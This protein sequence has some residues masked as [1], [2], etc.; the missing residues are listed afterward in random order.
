MPEHIHFT[1]G[2]TLKYTQ[3]DHKY[4]SN[5]ETHQSNGEGSVHIHTHTHLDY[6]TPGQG[7]SLR[8]TKKT[9]HEMNV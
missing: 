6:Y 9:K 1:E 7:T 8:K 4:R 5:G 2:H 3:A